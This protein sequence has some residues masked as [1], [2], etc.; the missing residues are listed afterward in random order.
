MIRP[1]AVSALAIIV[2]AS[3]DR[4]ASRTVQD[5]PP[6]GV[7]LTVADER[8]R[9]VSNLRYDL[10]FSIPADPLARIYA[11]ATLRFVLTDPGRT[12]VLDFAAAGPVHAESRGRPI[13]VAA[14]NEHIL[15]QT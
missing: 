13:A 1:V 11:T 15:I 9:R 12:L 7:P 5:N 6:A 2:M 4:F 14:V 8:A 3:T 10:H